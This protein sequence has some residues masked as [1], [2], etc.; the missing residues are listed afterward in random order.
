MNIYFLASSYHVIYGVTYF[1][2]NITVHISLTSHQQQRPC[3]IQHASWKLEKVTKVL[4]IP[5]ILKD[6]T[7]ILKCLPMAPLGAVPPKIPLTITPHPNSSG[8]VTVNFIYI[9]LH[10]KYLHLIPELWYGL[11]CSCYCHH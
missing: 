5:K 11:I 8:N 10:G 4:K 1:A 7:E 3:F 9:I 2:R 6:L